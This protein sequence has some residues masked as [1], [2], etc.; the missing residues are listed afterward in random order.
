MQLPTLQLPSFPHKVT[1]SA[2]E[3]RIFDPLRK[4]HVLLTPE[5]WVRQ[6][7]LHYLTA[8]LGYPRAL[9][10]VE[11]GLRYNRLQKRADVLV[12]DQTGQPLLLVECK[13]ASVPLTAAVCEQVAVYNATIGARVAAITNGMECYCWRLDPQAKQYVQL[14]HLPPYETL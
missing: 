9:I 5:E 6:H 4:K 2:S 3:L 1:Q 10:S 11:R 13:A 14:P 12:F 8:H 7:L